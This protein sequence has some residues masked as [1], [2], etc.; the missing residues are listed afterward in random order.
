MQR[1]IPI[2]LPADDEVISVLNAISHV[3][4]RLAKKLQANALQMPRTRKTQMCP[5]WQERMN[6]HEAVRG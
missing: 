4:S 3:S 5:L 1:Q 2:S 6:P